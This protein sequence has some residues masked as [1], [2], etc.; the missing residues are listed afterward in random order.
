MDERSARPE[1]SSHSTTPSRRVYSVLLAIRQAYPSNQID[2]RDPLGVWNTATADLSDDHIR[3]GIEQLSFRADAFAPSPGEFRKLC[4]ESYIRPAQARVEFTAPAPGSEGH[5]V[6]LCRAHALNRMNPE[7]GG[8]VA[9]SFDAAA[10]AVAETALQE[11][12]ADASIT[13]HRAFDRRLVS[14]ALDAY[15]KREAVTNGG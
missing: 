6:N 3:A 9:E 4:N 1:P 13:A 12:P 11:R 15:R 8:I 2:D 14:L 7:Y 10:D 5:F